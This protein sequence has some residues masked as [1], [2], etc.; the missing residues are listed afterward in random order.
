[1]FLNYL[2]KLILNDIYKFDLRII[3]IKHK[4]EKMF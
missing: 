2:I 4:S 3:I 1:M